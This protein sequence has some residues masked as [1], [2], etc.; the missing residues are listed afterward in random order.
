[1][2]APAPIR[3]VLAD[4]H[5]LVLEGLR[6]LL[7]AEPGVEILATATDGA[8]MEMKPRAVDVPVTRALGEGPQGR[9]SQIEAAVKTL[10]AQLDR[11]ATPR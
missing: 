10:L 2:T 9:D 7:A 1:M 5:A 6:N 8:D 11:R 3:V 4:D